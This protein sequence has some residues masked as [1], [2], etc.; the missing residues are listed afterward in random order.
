MNDNAITLLPGWSAEAILYGSGEA[1]IL[2]GI[3]ENGRKALFSIVLP[4]G[5]R[6]NAEKLISEAEKLR[7]AVGAKGIFTLA[8]YALL[9]DE[10]TQLF[11]CRFEE[12]GA[13]VT[14]EEGGGP[15]ALAS[16]IGSQT[17]RGISALRSLRLSARE[18]RPELIFR[19]GEGAH[20]SYRIIPTIPAA[21]PASSAEVAYAPENFLYA[22]PEMC[23][24]SAA[25]A[26][27]EKAELYSLALSLLAITGGSAPFSDGAP[28]DENPDG[29]RISLTRR[30]TG[31]D[32]IADVSGKLGGNPFDEELSAVLAETLSLNAAARTAAAADLSSVLSKL[33]AKYAPEEK[34]AAKAPERV[35]TEAEIKLEGTLEAIVAATQA[36]AP[37]QAPAPASVHAFTPAQTEAPKADDVPADAPAP[38]QSIP[39]EETVPVA[40]ETSAADDT[41]TFVFP[42]SDD[43]VSESPLFTDFPVSEEEA[44]PQPQDFGS[45][46]GTPAGPEESAEVPVSGHAVPS[47]E[48]TPDEPDEPVSGKHKKKKKKNKGKPEADAGTAG[49]SGDNW[50]AELLNEAMTEEAAASPEGT[51]IDLSRLKEINVGNAAADQ[52]SA[53]EEESADVDAGLLDQKL[54]GLTPEDLPV[55]ESENEE[56]LEPNPVEEE[57]PE[58]HSSAI[59]W[60]IAAIS[61]TVVVFT[62]FFLFAKGSIGSLGSSGEGTADGYA[63]ENK[64]VMPYIFN[65]TADQIKKELDYFNFAGKLTIEEEYNDE[66]EKGIAFWSNHEAADLLDNDEA[67]EVIVKISLGKAV[68]VP[69]YEGLTPDQFK[70]S[71]EELGLTADMRG[72]YNDEIAEGTITS[73]CLGE[74]PAAAPGEEN[75]SE[76]VCGDQIFADEQIPDGSIVIVNYSLGKEPEGMYLTLNSSDLT[77][78]TGRSHLLTAVIHNGGEGENKLTWKTSDP[79]IVSIESSSGNSARITTGKKGT[80]TVTVKCGDASAECRITVTTSVNSISLQGVPSSGIAV[81]QSVQLGVLFDPEKAENKDLNWSSSDSGVAMVSGSGRVTGIKTGT[82]RITATSVDGGKTASCVITVTDKNDNQEDITEEVTTAAPEEPGKVAV[83][84]LSLNLKNV[85][86]APGGSAIPTATVNPGNAENKNLTWSS[87]DPSVAVVDSHGNIT[88]VSKGTATI[89]ATTEDGGFTAS[90]TVTVSDSLIKVPSVAGLSEEEALAELDKAGFKI[91]Y[92]DGS[93]ENAPY[94]KAIAQSPAADANAEKGSVI[95]VTINRAESWSEWS[96]AL[97]EGVSESTHQ[98]ETRTEYSSREISVETSYIENKA[99]GD[100]WKVEVEKDPTGL[101]TRWSEIPISDTDSNLIVETKTEYRTREY[102]GEE[103]GWTAWTSWTDVEPEAADDIEIGTRTLYRSAECS[104][105]TKY[106]YRTYGEWSDWSETPAEASDTLDVTTREAYRWKEKH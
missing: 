86:L 9:E 38:E 35:R 42:K 6:G 37:A 71:L 14:A 72:E 36:Q 33:S 26:P 28:L 10:G 32:P 1:Y 23:T 59:L 47:A 78:S 79:T 49:G 58:G 96:P 3:S 103:S 12:D 27:A 44:A 91:A 52:S 18:I 106:F 30:L 77:I 90:C 66:T 29:M 8:D 82:A 69:S 76:N 100:Y 74:A 11:V 73:I 16:L 63:A 15:S 64:V 51:D 5:G 68:T 61:V 57:E 4:G 39:E 24:P 55:I 87:S 54:M 40:E 13:A 21:V 85:A 92:V 83:T 81:G 31:E 60:V 19:V 7:G 105:K 41:M 2:R 99:L 43:T 25:S 80:V 65:K 50:L 89:T 102:L 97:G 67:T 93:D 56:D 48:F 46:H 98:I 75:E 62:L 84:G 101:Y 22:A 34:A 53:L 88:A 95:T 70:A 45:A 104:R 20:C 94:G 17:A